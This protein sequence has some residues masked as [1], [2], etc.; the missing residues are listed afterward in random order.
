VARWKSAWAYSWKRTPR[1]RSDV[2]FAPARGEANLPVV[3]AGG[4]GD[5]AFLLV[6]AV[7]VEHH[8]DGPVREQVE[9]R[10]DAAVRRLHDLEAG[11]RSGDV[12]PT[13]EGHREVLGGHAL[14]PAEALG[15][16]PGALQAPGERDVPGVEPQ[17][18]LPGVERAG[19]VVAL[20]HVLAEREV[21]L[22]RRLVEGERGAGLLARALG[23]A[24]LRRGERHR[25]QDPGDVR[26]D[27]GLGGWQLLEA[28]EHRLDPGELAGPGEPLE[29]PGEELERP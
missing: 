19:E 5:V 29:L 25:A 10:A 21:G 12:R 1:K 13:I 22:G 2:A 20:E 7:R 6:G 16:A 17:A 3:D 9:E 11:A 14:Q 15:L 23:L 4:P 18:A 26:A 24:S 28:R 27:R 8:R